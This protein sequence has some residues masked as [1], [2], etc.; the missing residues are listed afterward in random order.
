MKKILR[1]AIVMFVAVWASVPLQAQH[2]T[3]TN[4]K[5]IKQFEKGQTY[6]Y[7]GRT[8][9]AVECFEQAVSADPKFVEA[10]LML[11]EWNL[12]AQHDDR[13]R[14]YYY[15]AVK[16]NPEFY[17]EAWLQL[18]NLE[19]KQ[20]NNAKAK[21]NYAT[22]LRL[23]K[24]RLDLRQQAEGGLRTAQFRIDAMANPVPFVPQNMGPEI[25]SADDEYLPAL[26]V[27]GSTLIFTRRF[28]RKSTSIC[29]TPEEEDFY[30]STFDGKWSK[31][32]RMPEPV[33]SNDNE[34][35]Q[36]ISQ[37][38]RIMFFT[39]CNRQ[40]GVG[41]CDLYMCVK[42]GD[43]WSKPRNLGPAVNSGAWE[44]QPTF[45]I[46]G[47]T[48][49]FVSD[50]KGGYGGKDI[51]FTTFKNGRWTAPQNLGPEI[52]TPY[53]EMS[54]FIHYSDQQ[55]Y[56]SS[57][58]HPGMGGMDLFVS[59]RTEKG[60]GIPQNLGY[61]INTAA[62]E[63]NLIVAADGRTAIYSSDRAGGY[64][65]QDLYQFEL[66]AAV[67]ALPTAHVH[68]FV[69]DKK[70]GAKL[71]STINVVD[72][73]TGDTVAVTSSDAGDGSYMVSLPKNGRYMFQVVS[74]G[75]LFYSDN[76]DETSTSDREEVYSRDIVLSAI[77]VGETITLRN[78]FFET[79]KYALL[80]ASIAE[81][82]SVVG[83]L[84]QNPTIKVELGGHTDN[85]GNTAANQLLSEQ[86]AKAVYD[87]LVAHGVSAER[88]SY[89]GYGETRPVA[90]NS[91]EEGRLANRRTTFTIV[92]K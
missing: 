26:T 55:L 29:D 53:D 82:Q 56:F 32:V 51:W 16:A 38:G 14:Q 67:R 41:R 36:C 90:D 73:E 8:T 40:D 19:L 52:N 71:K 2:Y 30:I 31:A 81:L 28:P 83:V 91:T 27:D 5:A 44:S 60:W 43:K 89:K 86:R 12:D 34:G 63:T 49:Y 66:P 72:L 23:D 22:F 85:V 46:D 37:D 42:K 77:E 20:G 33:N 76:F 88:L 13:A 39:A 80:D 62:D 15:A 1:Y 84:T 25:N 21:E 65:K 64:G 87:Y 58:G 18:G 4:S 69:S 45:S 50:R 70:S 79:G 17:T 7:Q 3:T 11:A 78:I 24:G 92:N 74:D 57:N 9:E 68:G 35:A 10:N 54:P 48:L 6:L 75:Y 47:R 61:P 59:T